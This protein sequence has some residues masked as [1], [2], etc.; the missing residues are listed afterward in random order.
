LA[1]FSHLALR[2]FWPPAGLALLLAF[3]HF[4]WISGCLLAF[5][6][7]SG[8]LAFFWLSGLH[9]AFRPSSDFLALLFGAIYLSLTT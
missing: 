4:F 2:F 5:W 7:S 8:F 9:L 3:W 6:P 1:S